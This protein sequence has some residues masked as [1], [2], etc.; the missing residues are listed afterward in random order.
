MTHKAHNAIHHLPL[1][2]S[3][4]VHAAAAPEEPQDD[5]PHEPDLVAVI[6]LPGCRV[7]RGHVRELT[8]VTENPG[9]ELGICTKC[10]G[11]AR[12]MGSAVSIESYHR[13]HRT[14]CA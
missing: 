5:Q 13:H 6:V 14:D 1:S 3:R 9:M 10:I 7:G 4:T 11:A 2:S 8:D 12:S